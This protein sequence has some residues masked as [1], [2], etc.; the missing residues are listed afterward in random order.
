MRTTFLPFIALCCVVYAKSNFSEV[1]WF[2]SA[3]E[4]GSFHPSLGLGIQPVSRVC[5]HNN[6]SNL[7]VS[8]FDIKAVFHKF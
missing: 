5:E 4:P 3:K 8:D 6:I 2:L 1:C 7:L